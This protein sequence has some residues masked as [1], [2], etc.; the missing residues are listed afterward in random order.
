[1]L[2]GLC[3]RYVNSN[4]IWL[5]WHHMSVMASQSSGNPTDCSTTCSGYQQ[6]NNISSVLLCKGNPP[7]MTDGSSHK[8]PVMRKAFPC[9]NIV[10][11]IDMSLIARFMGPTWGPSGAY[12]TQV[13]PM[14]APWTLLSGVCCSFIQRIA[15][16]P[17]FWAGAVHKAIGF[18]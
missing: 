3:I 5:E 10:M 15:S 11:S 6:I 16:V 9:H 4:R 17:F 1:M 2:C 18:F 12:R 8:G 13:G 7:P 14:M